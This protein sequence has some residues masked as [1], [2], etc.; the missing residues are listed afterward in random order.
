M[1][2]AGANTQRLVLVTPE[3]DLIGD[4]IDGHDCQNIEAGA[5]GK[6]IRLAGWI[7]IENRISVSRNHLLQPLYKS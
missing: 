1:G 7:D 3:N 5:K 2:L 4:R 6:L